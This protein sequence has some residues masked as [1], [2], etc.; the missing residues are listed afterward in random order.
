MRVGGADLV[1]QHAEKNHG[2]REQQE[3]PENGQDR[4]YLPRRPRRINLLGGSW[5]SG[6]RP[7]HAVDYGPRAAGLPAASRGPGGPG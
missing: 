1:V 7:R 5:V 2:E 3:G 4:Y 6:R